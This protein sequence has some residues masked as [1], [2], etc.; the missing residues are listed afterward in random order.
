MLKIGANWKYKIFFCEKVHERLFLGMS[1]KSKQN[2]NNPRNLNK[3][4]MDILL[5]LPGFCLDIRVL[6]LV[7]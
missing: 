5:G 1:R 2:N 3:K 7:S 6:C 4:K